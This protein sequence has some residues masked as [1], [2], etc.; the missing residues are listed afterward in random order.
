MPSLAVGALA[1]EIGATA[2]D[3]TPIRLDAFRGKW[4]VLF[5][6][7]R[8]FTSGCTIE[9][10]LFRDRH[11]EIRALGAA[12]VGVSIDDADTQC[13]FAEHH[14]LGFPLIADADGR[15]V[16]AYGVKRPLVETAKRVT[17]VIDPDGRVAAR[18][19]HELRFRKHVDD[20]I[21]FL[22]SRGARG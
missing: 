13:R 17:F 4:L 19:H 3:G 5:F 8:S 15:V 12:V 14:Q 18:F 11:H 7:P 22:K 16:R 2:H 9:S 1:P 20:V 21:D 6:Y 10:K